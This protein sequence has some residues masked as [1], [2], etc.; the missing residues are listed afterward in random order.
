MAA[1]LWKEVF[2]LKY[3]HPKD[4]IKNK[5]IGFCSGHWA[6]AQRKPKGSEISMSKTYLHSQV[7]CSTVHNSQDTEST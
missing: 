3:L 2:L 1:C 5:E 7:P 4:E 6:I